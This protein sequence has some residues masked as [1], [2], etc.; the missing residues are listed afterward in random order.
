M[1]PVPSVLVLASALLCSSLLLAQELNESALMAFT[2]KI[3]AASASRDID[4]VVDHIAEHAVISGTANVQGQMR[5]LRMNKAQY[6]QMLTLTWSAASSYTYERTN[7]K[8]SIDGDQAIVTADVA[9]TMVIQGQEIRTRT[10][11]R[12][13]V[14]S[15]DGKLM[16]TGL[17]ANQI[18]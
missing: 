13:T 8:I 6:R 11:E 12:A 15:I 2:A 14:K 1:R 18:M 9:E 16:L 4:T 3:D 5:A 7:E 17:I 10:R